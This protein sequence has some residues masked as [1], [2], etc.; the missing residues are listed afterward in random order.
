[1]C[2]SISVKRAPRCLDDLKHY[3]ASEF[4][5]V[6][7]MYLPVMY[8]VIPELYMSHLS[9]LSSAIFILYQSSI[10]RAELEVARTHSTGAVHGGQ[11][12]LP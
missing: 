2:A 10:T 12:V 4:A 6:L 8:D 11:S 9:L 3:K 7:L 1:M 5:T